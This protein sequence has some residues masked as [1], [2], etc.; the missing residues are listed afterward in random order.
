MTENIPPYVKPSSTPLGLD[1]AL[2]D[3]TSGEA[4]KGLEEAP[5][6]QI[7]PPSPASAHG[8]P[9]TIAGFGH[10]TRRRQRIPMSVPQQRLEVQSIPGW[11][12]YWFKEENVARAYSDSHYDFV[13]NEEVALNR[14]SIAGRPGQSGNTDLGSAVSIVA[15]TD[16]HGNPQRLVL[17]KLPME[18][19]KEDQGILMQK[20]VQRLSGVFE[21]EK[22][23]G[24][25]GE[26]NDAGQ[27]VYSNDMS[28]R[29]K[30]TFV[31]LMNRPVRKAKVG[32]GGRL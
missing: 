20:S 12:L 22:I 3:R 26:I 7:L 17:M 10:L 9:A 11:R 16:Q 1:P 30:G 18:Y 6:S 24:E 28:F 29:S 31:P 8:S 27:L 23:F 15:G 2:L 32:R 14:I 19:F 13:T 5:S 4:F 21:G 25:D